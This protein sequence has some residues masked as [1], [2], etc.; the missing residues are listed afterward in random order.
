[1][2]WAVASITDWSTLGDDRERGSHWRQSIVLAA[3]GTARNAGPKRPL[4]AMLGKHLQGPPGI[5]VHKEY[6]NPNSTL[7]ASV[8][9]I[10]WA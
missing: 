8:A 10:L 3:G 6:C 4:A 2:L 5:T 7:N 9:W 1:M